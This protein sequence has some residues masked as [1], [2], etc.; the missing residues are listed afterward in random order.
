MLIALY[1][2]I[3]IHIYT[4]IY[5]FHLYGNIP[6]TQKDVVFQHKSQALYTTKP[7]ISFFGH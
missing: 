7:R 6:S 2:Y 3:Y 5:A 1:T 4:Y